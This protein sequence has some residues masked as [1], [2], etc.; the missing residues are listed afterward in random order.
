MHDG[1]LRYRQT[2]TIL[3]WIQYAFRKAELRFQNAGL[4]QPA[5]PLRQRAYK[6]QEP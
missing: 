3:G 5:P 2:M 1:Y 4:A 6:D